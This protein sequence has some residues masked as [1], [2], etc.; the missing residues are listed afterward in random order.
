[1]QLTI[2][3]IGNKI[4]FSLLVASMILGAA[5]V[6]HAPS[7]HRLFGYPVLSLAIFSVSALM[8]LWLIVAIMRSGT[9]R[10]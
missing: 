9:L 6:M 3:V 1:L 5:I 10:Q 4:S 8:A 7:T 2:A